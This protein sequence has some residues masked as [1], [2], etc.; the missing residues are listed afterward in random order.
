MK[1]NAALLTITF[2]G[3][4]DRR[5][6]WSDDA[7]RDRGRRRDRI[8]ARRPA[9]ASCRRP[10]LRAAPG[11]AEAASSLNASAF[12]IGIGGGALL[13][14]LTVDQWGPGYLPIAAGVL[15][16]VGLLVIA[17]SRRVGAPA[18]AGTAIE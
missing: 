10:T 2:A 1:A 18:A 11:A 15:V 17:F 14:G 6:S 9:G 3:V 12:N 5:R 13:G 8:G 4:G 16:G 7:A